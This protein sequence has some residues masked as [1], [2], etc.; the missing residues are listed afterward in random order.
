MAVRPDLQNMPGTF[1]AIT[2]STTDDFGFPA[3]DGSRF[4]LRKAR[5]T[6]LW[7]AFVVGHPIGTL[8]DLLPSTPLQQIT[9]LPTD[10]LFALLLF[11]AFG[12][13]VF[14]ARLLWRFSFPKSVTCWIDSLTCMLG[15]L[16]V[17]C[18]A[19]DQLEDAPLFAHGPRRVWLSFCAILG[20]VIVGILMARFLSLSADVKRPTFRTILGYLVLISIGTIG[21]T[22]FRL[23]HRITN[24]ELFGSGFGV[25][26]TLVDDREHFGV[27]DEGRLV[28]IYRFSLDEQK[29]AAFENSFD[30]RFSQFTTALIH[31][32]DA[33]EKNNCHGWVFTGGR[34]LLRGDGVQMILEDND[35]QL[36]NTPVPGDIIIYRDLHGVIIHTGLVQGI[37][38]EGTVMIESKW[39]IDQRFL[40]L[41]EHQPY[42][43]VYEY[44]HTDRGSHLIDVQSRSMEFA[45]EGG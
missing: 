29:F 39:G 12:S 23:N 15:L 27:T 43:Q 22:L 42:S 17:C 44:Y 33:D 45:Y 1:L 11:A 16:S 32:H 26:G 9:N 37:L 31:R 41:P 24:Y 3:R 14:L 10:N 18:I 34:F 8:N 7:H 35:Y 13:S 36:V 5:R 19:I 40:H 2:G 38:K 20:V 4:A 6:P 21:A 25:P 28:P 30:K